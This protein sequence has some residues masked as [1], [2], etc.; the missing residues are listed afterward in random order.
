MSE[1]IIEILRKNAADIVKKHTAASFCRVMNSL[2][3]DVLFFVEYQDDLDREDFIVS[4]I[5]DPNSEPMILVPI[6]VRSKNLKF[7]IERYWEDLGFTIYQTLCHEYI[8]LEQ[9]CKRDDDGTPV[10]NYNNDF[11][12]YLDSYD[13]IDAY[14]NDMALEL[15]FNY[16]YEVALKLLATPR[17]IRKS[18]TLSLYRTAFRG[19]NWTHTRQKLLAKVYRKLTRS[20]LCIPPKSSNWS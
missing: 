18:R 5:C 20:V 2:F 8:H 11:R 6:F 12:N 14:S 17:K 4:G 10:L 19:V 1:E 9:F 15:L 3:E 7:D 16:K 13:E